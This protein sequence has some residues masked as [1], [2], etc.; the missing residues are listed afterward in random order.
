MSE[1]YIQKYKRL[2][3]KIVSFLRKKKKEYFNT[4]A[5]ASNK[6]FW[7]TI[8]LLDKNRGTIP[9]LRYHDCTV[10]QDSEKAEVLNEFFASCWN[11]VDQPLSE[12]HYHCTDLPIY[13]ITPEE[14]FTLTNKLDINKA[15][16]P[17]CISAYMLKATAGSIASPLAKLFNLSLTT[18]KFPQMWKTASIV[19]IPKSGDKSDPSNYR[20][21][22]LLSI[23][24]KLLEK[25]VYSLLWDHLTEH[26][27]ISACQ[28]GFQKGKSTTTALLSTIHD[29]CSLLDKHYDIACI[30]FDFKKAFDSVPYQK[31]MEKLSQLD[32]PLSILS[33][34]CSY[35]SGRRQFV[36][37]NIEHSKSI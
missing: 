32:L 18:G 23:V 2:R 17:D 25:I 12:D 16:G 35:L 29:W 1:V 19:L 30:F 22:S 31:M 36:L 24:S 20:P 6:E 28:W 13:E 5:T 37:V 7:K 26:A 15:N 11:T 34:F 21:V 27:P 10:S 33:W 14:V 9:A 3:N 8:K 4:L